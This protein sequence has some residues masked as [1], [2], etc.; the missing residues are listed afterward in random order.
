MKKMQHIKLFSHND[1]DGFGAPC[2]FMT[3]APYMFKGV[4]F[5]LTS[6]SAGRLDRE[7]EHWFRQPDIQRYT[8]VYIMDMTPDSAYSFKLLEQKFANHWLVFDHHESEAE[9]RAGH[10]KNCIEPLDADVA[11]SAVSLVWDYLTQQQN[12]ALVPEERRR[13]LAELVEMIRAYDTWD[14]QNDPDMPYEK[15][16]ASDE[17]NQLFWFFPLSR[18]ESFVTSVFDAGWER[19]R[20]EHSLLISTLEGR[21]QRYLDKHLKDVETFE[22]E[23]HSFGVV[24]ASDYKS[25]IAHELLRKHD[26]DAALV[27]DG[28]SVSLRSNGRLDVAKFAEDYFGGG[29]HADS[30][31]GRLEVEPIRAAERTVIESVR[32]R[33]RLNEEVAAQNREEA[34]SLGDA[35]D[36]EMAA[37]LAAMFGGDDK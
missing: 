22:L 14:F 23:G 16:R 31:G 5:D 2:L 4:E 28:H 13:E 26:V 6:C 33:A 35:I 10:A 11:P 37:K 19:Y 36:P 18:S 27:I 29:G 7:L 12:F 9:L 20:S 15:R 30:A 3:L 25:E 8:D 32:Q 21:R 1:L 24:Y 34:S 17:L